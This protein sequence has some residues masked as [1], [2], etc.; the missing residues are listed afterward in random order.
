MKTQLLT[1]MTAGLLTVGG[2][3][4]CDDSATTQ[5]GKTPIAPVLASDEIA[6]FFDKYLPSV[7]GSAESECFF[8]DEDRSKCLIVNSASELKAII[9]SSVEPPT[10][11]FDKYTLIIGQQV[12][13]TTSFSVLKQNLNIGTNKITLDL[14][15]KIPE[16]SY[17]AFSRLYYWGLYPKFSGNTIDINV[18][19]EQ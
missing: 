14:T 2:F 17:P 12:M 13:P 8:V 5:A 7:S 16:S 1:L 4:A 19:S 6:A 18:I 9:Y 10:I 3:S 15:V 11:D